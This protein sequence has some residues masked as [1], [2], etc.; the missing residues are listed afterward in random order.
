METR[1]KLYQLRRRLKN[2]RFSFSRKVL[3]S[4]IR[5]TFLSGN[6]DELGIEDNDILCYVLPF[7]SSADLLV[8]DMACEYGGLPSPAGAIQDI[9]EDRAVF[10]LGRPEGTLG[11]RSQRQQSMRMTRLFDHQVALKEGTDTRIKVV[12]ISIFWGHQPDREKS[13]FKILLSEHWSATSGMK[14]FLAGLF[15]PSHILVQ[16]GT[17]IDQKSVV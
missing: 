12:P 17:P 3:F 8:A 6:P 14:K 2:V 16:F 1:P 10:F 11:R 4:W 15:H 9:E 5:P 13:L 7:R